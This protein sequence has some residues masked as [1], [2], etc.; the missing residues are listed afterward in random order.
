[1]REASPASASSEGVRIVPGFFEETLPALAGDRWALMRLDGDTYE[2][3]WLTLAA[4]YGGLAARRLRD[5]RRLPRHAHG[6]RP[7][8][9][10]VPRAARHRRSRSRRSTGRACA[11]GARAT[12]RSRRRR[13]PRSAPT[14]TQAPARVGTGLPRS[15]RELELDRRGRGAARATRRAAERRRTAGCW[16]AGRLRRRMIAFGCA[17][18]RP[19]VY[20]ALRGAGHPARRRARG[21]RATTRR[22]QRHDRSQNYNAL[23]DA[24]AGAPRTSRRS[25]SSTRT[26]RSSTTD[27][28]ADDPRHA[29][30]PRRSASIGCVGAIG[31]RSIAWWEGSV[32]L[33]SFI[34]RYDEHGGGDLHSFSWNWDEAPPVRAHRR[35]RHARRLPARAAAVGRAQSALRRVARRLPRLRPRLLPAGPRGGPQGRHRRLP[36]H[37]PPAAGDAS[38]TREEW[39]EAHIRVAEKW[40][41]RMPGIGAA[42]GDVAGARAAAPR[43]SATPR[44][45]RAP[46][47]ALRDRGARPRAR[48]RARARRA[49]ASR[50][51]SRR[52]C[53]CRRAACASSPRRRARVIAFG[54]FVAEERRVPRPR[55]PGHRARGRARLGGRSP[56]RR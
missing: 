6:V 38:P 16:R 40:D 17:I 36:G 9:R 55:G 25:C 7:R 42:A 14:R 3:T 53:G 5:R 54:T 45:P 52:R 41:G 46:T 26:R 2:A 15:E 50:G 34:N 35:G 13:R 8:G 28:C 4:L 19:D 10:R 12:P 37:P 49:R 23:L 22:S 27:F 39:V 31:V 11:G 24:A 1:M 20:R 44:A 29:R 56:T 48:A 33:A 51:A 30:R 21:G 47:T 43:P 18:T 32:T